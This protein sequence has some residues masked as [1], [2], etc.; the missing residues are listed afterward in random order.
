MRPWQAVAMQLGMIGLGRM[1]A[2]MSRRLMAA[3]HEC[4]VH[5]V[6]S[7]AID[8]L[9]AEGATP[10]GSLDELVAALRPPRHV[11]VMIPA[12][13]VGDTVERLAP[14]LTSGDTIIDGGNSWY[15]DDV[16]RSG[17][18]GEELGLHYVDVGTSGGVHGLE[19]GYCLMIGG[20]V[21][22]GPTSWIR[23]FGRTESRH[24]GGVSHRADPEPRG[25]EH[26]AVEHG[27]LHCGP[28]RRGAL[29]ED[30]PQRHRVRGDVRLRRGPQRAGQGRTSVADRPRRGRRDR[31]TR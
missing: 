31:P 16:D 22:R 27:Y 11:W 29:R 14:L 19:R 13:F 7:E 5:D 12:A 24:G 25:S 2:N 28:V 23:S 8:E 18:L 30:G 26:S 1:G 10:A 21:G 3:G 9:A 6:S 15:R 20:D 17:P 4:V